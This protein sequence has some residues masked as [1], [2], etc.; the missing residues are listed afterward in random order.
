MD[1]KTFIIKGEIHYV[2]PHKYENGNS[3]MCYRCRYFAEDVKQK[4]PYKKTGE[5]RSMAHQTER[6]YTHRQKGWD[7]T[8]DNWSCHWWFP[9]GKQPGEQE[10]II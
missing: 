6:G 10:Q 9:I 5:C 1:D 3:T 8:E 4:Y 7:R 2:N